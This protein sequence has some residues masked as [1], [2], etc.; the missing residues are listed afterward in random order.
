MDQ[1]DVQKPIKRN[2]R[3]MTPKC[4]IIKNRSKGIKLLIKYNKDGIFVGDASVHLTSYLVLIHIIFWAIS[5]FLAPQT[6]FIDR[7]LF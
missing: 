7:F 6:E 4:M 5:F 2:Y 3:G 1:D